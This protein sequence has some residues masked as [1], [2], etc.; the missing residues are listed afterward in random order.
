MRC[1]ALFSGGK[2][3]TYAVFLAIEYGYDVSCLVSIVSENLDSY[4]FHTPSISEVKKQS[5]VMGIPLLVQE[6]RGV[7]EEELKD[8][9]NVI[10]R[11]KVDFD[12]EGV[13]TGSVESAYQAS[14]VQRICNELGLE[15]FNPLW[16]KDQLE[17][18]QDIVRNHFDVIVTSVSAYPLNRSWL[19]RKIDEKFIHDV[20]DLY[21]RFGINPAGEGGE[22]ETFVLWCPLFGRS[23]TVV[24]EQVSG[25]NNSWRM[26]IKVI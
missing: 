9:K 6:T 8:L 11:A 20:E 13:I 4:M 18:L 17:L 19:G 23:L 1:A 7:K 26:E 22:F 16:Q 12:V 15:C 25:R 2:D 24:D 10:E 21:S 3:S 5:E 14:R